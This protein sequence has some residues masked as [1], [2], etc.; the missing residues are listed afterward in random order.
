M[1]TALLKIMLLSL[2]FF[3]SCSL[4][5]PIFSLNC[6]RY[7]TDKY[8]FRASVEVSS[9]TL[10]LAQ[11]KAISMANN[12]MLSQVDNYIAEKISYKDFLADDKYEEKL[13]LIRTKALEACEI[14]CSHVSQK[15]GA[16]IYSTT[17]QLN[18][19]TMD[20]IISNCK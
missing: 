4:L 1:R 15:N 10:P 13:D 19:S 3:S 17:L 20:E 7:T 16:I 8:V 6:K 12:D 18:R 14:S 11:A 9:A 2:I 5:R